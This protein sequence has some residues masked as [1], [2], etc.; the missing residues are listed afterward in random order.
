MA[1]VIALGKPDVSGDDV[2]DATIR[3]C[4]SEAAMICVGNQFEVDLVA[5]GVF[6]GETGAGIAVD[7]GG[8][9]EA[10]MVFGGIIALV[11]S[12]GAAGIVVGDSGAGET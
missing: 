6:D 2:C 11:V 10:V 1:G 5:P 12:V 7:T 3:L 4:V 8:A 9:G